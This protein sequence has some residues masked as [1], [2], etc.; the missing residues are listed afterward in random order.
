MAPS[1]WCRPV[2]TGPESNDLRDDIFE[3]V[4]M[5]LTYFAGIK[6]GRCIPSPKREFGAGMRW[7]A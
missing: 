6:R 3:L 7:I 5:I 2:R 4:Y 1:K